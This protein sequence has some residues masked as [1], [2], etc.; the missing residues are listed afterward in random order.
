MYEDCK[1]RKGGHWVPGNL[2]TLTLDGKIV[3]TMKSLDFKWGGEIKG[4]QKDFMHF[5]PSGY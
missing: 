2:G 4:W 3:R 5:S 1:L